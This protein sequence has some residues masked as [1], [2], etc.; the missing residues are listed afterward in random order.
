MG[1]ERIRKKREK[2]KLPSTNDISFES[3][4]YDLVDNP[5]KII[6]KKGDSPK[7]DIN[8]VKL[9]KEGKK[10]KFYT[11]VNKYFIRKKRY[12]KESEYTYVKQY[13]GPI[14]IL[15]NQFIRTKDLKIYKNLI[16]DTYKSDYFSFMYTKYPKEENMNYIETLMYYYYI[17]LYNDIQQFPR[18]K[19]PFKTLRGVDNFSYYMKDH[20][21]THYLTDFLSTTIS[22]SV[23]A[24]Y[25]YGVK[26][27]NETF[28]IINFIIYPNCEYAYIKNY[29]FH[30]NEE[31]LLLS[32]FNRYLYIKEKRL[33]ENEL[34]EY[35]D[36]DPNNEYTKFV[37]VYM[38]DVGI[39]MAYFLVLPC[40]FN[41]E[42]LADNIKKILKQ[43]TPIGNSFGNN[44]KPTIITKKRTSKE[45][46]LVNYFKQQL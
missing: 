32:P 31:E 16:R 1:E 7:F 10:G 41:A 14:Y 17:Y 29:S 4:A 22:L 39:N 26:N 33:E 23:A 40:D 28:N 15:I 13:S 42:F 45:N 6:F 2:I 19:K 3:E 34:Q 12:T 20:D 8:G 27:E 9:Y 21:K 36:N 24:G 30:P 44:D 18:L 35:I 25:S 37:N 46:D 38:K 5:P 43:N 11:L